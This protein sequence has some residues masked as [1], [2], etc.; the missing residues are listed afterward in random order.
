[1]NLMNY[2]D[3][4]DE[5]MHGTDQAGSMMDQA[6]EGHLYPMGITD[7]TSAYFFLSDDA[8]DEIAGSDKKRMKCRSCGHRFTR[9][10]YD[11]CPKCDSLDTEEVL[12]FIDSADDAGEVPN[13]KCLDCGHTFVGDI[14]DRCP[15]C[16]SS[17]TE[18]L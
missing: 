12:S 8:Q 18:K 6:A 10:T 17:G 7:P 14:Y 11:R 3:E 9:E 2:D 13:M 15:E 5:M 1:M 4:L 16:F